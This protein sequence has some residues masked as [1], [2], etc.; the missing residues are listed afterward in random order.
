MKKLT[1]SLLILFATLV[2]GSKVSFGVTNDATGRSLSTA[3]DALTFTD[4]SEAAGVFE[5]NLG[6]GAAW[7]DYDGDGYIDIMTVGHLGSICQLW[8]NDGD[9]TFTDVTIAAGMLTADGDAH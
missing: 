2:T 6:W 8:H 9:G 7:G 1:L 4:V 5:F 3:P